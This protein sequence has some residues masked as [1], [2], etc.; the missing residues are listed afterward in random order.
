M[1]G[2][3]FH[4][5]F[6]SQACHYCDFHFSTNRSKQQEMVLALLEELRLRQ[7]YLAS[8][9]VDSIYF[10]G[11]TPS[12]LSRMQLADLLSACHALFDVSASTEVTFEANP[13]DITPEQLSI[14]QD[15]GVNRLSVGIQ[16]FHDPLLQF[17]NRAHSA[18]EAHAA[19]LAINE[20]GFSNWSMDLIY[21]LHSQ[22]DELWQ[23]D[24]A[25]ALDYRPSHISSYC[26]TIEPKT[27]FGNWQ[28]K[29]KLSAVSEEQANRQ[30]ML[31]CEQLTLEGFDHY[32]VS[33]FGLPGKHAKH[34]SN[35]WLQQAY[36]GIGPSAHSYNGHS[37]QYNVA[38]NATYIRQIGACVIPAEIEEL[39][40]ADQYNEYV[41]VSLRTSWGCSLSYIKERFGVDLQ[42]RFTSKLEQLAADRLGHIQVGGRF[43]LSEEGRLFADG[44]AADFFIEQL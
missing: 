2:I 33:N 19:L 16:S 31:L 22:T 32:E 36:L 40:K 17:M 28:Q 15:A 8:E 1:A 21:G 11:G 13:D 9:Q 18:Q 30:Y 7:P 37:R 5:P 24:I 43:I 25:Y 20:A 39:S 26:L 38:N 42:Q 29:G 23:E 12:L 44:I 34:N 27:A 4:I 41:M 14:W 10:G 6:C 3:Y 35:Y